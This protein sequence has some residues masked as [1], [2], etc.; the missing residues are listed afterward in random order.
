M[1]QLLRPVGDDATSTGA[2]VVVA[3][4]A[5]RT[6]GE[7]LRY[8]SIPDLVLAASPQPNWVVVAQSVTE[9]RTTNSRRHH[10]SVKLWRQRFQAEE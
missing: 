8:H 5:A 4:A 2:D 9:E 1:A 7:L 6:Y 10:S 3:I